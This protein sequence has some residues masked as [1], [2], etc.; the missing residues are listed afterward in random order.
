MKF[1]KA[2]KAKMRK[3]RQATIIRNFKDSYHRCIRRWEYDETIRTEL[4]ESK[5]RQGINAFFEKYKE[6]SY[7]IVDKAIID[8]DLYLLGETMCYEKDFPE[9]DK[10]V[11]FKVL[12]HFR[13]SRLSPKRL[14]ENKC[15]FE[16]AKTWT[17]R[18]RLEISEQ[19]RI[20]R[21]S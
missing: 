13:Y 11:I 9:M 19:G 18:S 8:G 3:R 6:P 7:D 21:I 20:N 10:V 2:K 14:L 4:K 5:T 16:T 17:R 15:A 12:P 1:S